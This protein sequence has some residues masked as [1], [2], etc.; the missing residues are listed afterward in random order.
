MKVAISGASGFVGTALQAHF[1]DAV[2]LNRDDTISTLVDKL[3]GVA[4]VINLSGAPIIKRWS[5][6]YKRRL[7]SSRIDTT[8][9]LVEAI[10]HSEV[11]H[12]ISTSAVGIYPNAAACDE[13]CAIE[14]FDFLSEL[15]IAWESE[16]KQ[17][18]KPTT[19]LR[20]GVVLDPLGGA[21]HKMLLPFKLGLGGVI[22]NGA[23]QM[24]WITLHDLVRLFAFCAEK[25]LT[26]TYNASSPH[27]LSNREFT[28]ILA[29]ALHR[30]AFLPLPE[31]V[32][33]LMYGEGASVLTDSKEVYPNALLSEGFSFDH[34]TLEEAFSTFF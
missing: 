25:Q 24:S 34:P 27:P 21:L 9:K 3:Q 20:F 16:A 23:M 5:V 13:S 26:G 14:A 15:C 29:K 30:P 11:K 12:F 1:T 19:I 32:L 2:V 4:L 18:Q 8:K 7:Y 10:N 31:F 17:C 28:K 22:G 6:A 33:K